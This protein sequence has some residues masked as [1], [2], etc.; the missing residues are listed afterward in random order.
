MRTMKRGWFYESF[1]HALSAK[2]ISTRKRKARVAA[3]RKNSAPFD[4][5]ARKFFAVKDGDGLLKVP[6]LADSG[7]ELKARNVE[8]MRG[9]AVNELQKDEGKL[10]RGS[11][12]RFME[13]DFKRHSDDYLSG[14]VDHVTYRENVK[15]G[16]QRFKDANRNDRIPAFDWAGDAA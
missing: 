13:D 16:V 5:R 12:Q 4:W 2:G 3:A 10:W 8:M 9:E 6:E 14:T 15:K 1:R 11:V 7:K